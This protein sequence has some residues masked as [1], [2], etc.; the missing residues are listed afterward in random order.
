MKITSDSGILPGYVAVGA[1]VSSLWG[2][3]IF[4][5]YLRPVSGPTTAVKSPYRT[6]LPV[7]L[8]IVNED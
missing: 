1:E 7:L 4:F 2:P 5:S 6:L 8:I 3:L